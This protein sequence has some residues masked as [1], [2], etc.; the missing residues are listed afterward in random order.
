LKLIKYSHYLPIWD[1][2]EKYTPLES[3]VHVDHG[4]DA[5][6]KFTELLTE[7][8][9]IKNLSPTTGS[10][11]TGVQLSKLSRAGKNQLVLLVAQRKVVA[12]RG[13][14]FADLPI[15][16]A[17]DFGGYFGRHH[18]HPTSGAPEGYPEVHLVH[19]VGSSSEFDEFLANRN[20]SV[21]WHSD[22]TYE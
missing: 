4:K 6:P 3:F 5:E 19:R 12:F 22:V 20:S 1:H 13:Q 14:D 9:K 7:G 10:E 8:A 16:E 2:S 11:V 18:I 15:Q 21:G 17:L